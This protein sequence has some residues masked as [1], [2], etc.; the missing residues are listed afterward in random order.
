MPTPEADHPYSGG[1]GTKAKNT[2]A[3][4][5]FNAGL[6]ASWLRGDGPEAALQ[7]GV[8]AST[9]AAGRVGTRPAAGAAPTTGARPTGSRPPGGPR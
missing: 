1:A 5:A 3:G 6:L 4:D 7:H 8:A 9:A 2:G